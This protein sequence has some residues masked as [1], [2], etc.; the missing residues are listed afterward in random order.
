M[1]T[2]S[3]ALAEV[4]SLSLSLQLAS[5]KARNPKLEFTGVCSN[6]SRLCKGHMKLSVCTHAVALT[7]NSERWPDVTHVLQDEVTKHN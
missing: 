3:V 2:V 6:T 4:C 5:C 7:F 1:N